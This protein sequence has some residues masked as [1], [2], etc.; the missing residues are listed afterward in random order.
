MSQIPQK[1][2]KNRPND[3]VNDQRLF[4]TRISGATVL[5]L[6]TT[7]EI[8]PARKLPRKIIVFMMVLVAIIL[9]VGIPVGAMISGKNIFV[10][11]S[12]KEIIGVVPLIHKGYT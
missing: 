2:T 9:I 7:N 10:F 12:F 8:I 1:S 11:F 5:Q 3:T 4:R 6:E